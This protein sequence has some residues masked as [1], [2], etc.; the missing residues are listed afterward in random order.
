MARKACKALHESLWVVSHMLHRLDPENAL[1]YN[2]ES[3]IPYELNVND[4]PLPLVS[5]F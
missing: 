2:D 3:Q 5:E 4:I 1:L